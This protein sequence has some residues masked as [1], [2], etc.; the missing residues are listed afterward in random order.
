MGRGS[1]REGEGREWDEEGKG[2]EKSL[3]RNLSCQMYSYV[4]SPTTPHINYQGQVHVSVRRTPH[5]T[6][7]ISQKKKIT[8]T[9]KNHMFTMSHEPNSLAHSTHSDT[10]DGR[11]NIWKVLNN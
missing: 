7:T 11:M 1:G 10:V 8:I 2:R 3:S 5:L 6:V 4:V 9:S